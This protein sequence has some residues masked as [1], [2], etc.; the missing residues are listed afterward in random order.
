VLADATR[1][2]VEA[3]MAAAGGGRERSTEK[4]EISET[5]R[6]HMPKKET[7]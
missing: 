1:D 7:I 4:L 6:V 3:N 5:T 2:E